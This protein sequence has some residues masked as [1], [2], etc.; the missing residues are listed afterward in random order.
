MILEQAAIWL[1]TTSAPPVQGRRGGA[2]DLISASG[3][4]SRNIVGINSRT[5]LFIRL[6]RD[7]GSEKVP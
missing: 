1:H 7:G 4:Y 2:G 5:F 6:W 3:H